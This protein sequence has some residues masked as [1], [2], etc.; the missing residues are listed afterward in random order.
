MLLIFH[1]L[2]FNFL[3]LSKQIPKLR[4]FL[5]LT[6]VFFINQA[7]LISSFLGTPL[8]LSKISTTSERNLKL[9]QKITCWDFNRKINSSTFIILG[10]IWMGSVMC[11][12]YFSFHA[13]VLLQYLISPPSQL[14]FLHYPRL[15][16]PFIQTHSKKKKKLKSIVVHQYQLVPFF[17]F[18]SKGMLFESF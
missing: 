16:A 1:V 3:W 2:Y 14:L 5:L 15:N 13:T 18:I 12:A 9:E 6:F 7:S 8:L 11:S 10:W 17:N 4:L